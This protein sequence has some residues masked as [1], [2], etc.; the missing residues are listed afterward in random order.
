VAFDPW[1]VGATERHEQP[2]LRKALRTAAD[3]VSNPLALAAAATAVAFFSFL[4]TSYK[5]LFELGL[6]AD[7]GMLIAFICSITFVRRCWLS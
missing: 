4:P 5:G 6:I 1:F 3:K 2:D 7:C